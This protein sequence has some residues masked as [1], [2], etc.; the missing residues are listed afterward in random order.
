MI[1]A[2]NILLVYVGTMAI[3]GAAE[4]HFNKRK[5]KPV[6]KPVEEI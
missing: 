3:I 1:R 6:E 2:L 5:Q 4:K